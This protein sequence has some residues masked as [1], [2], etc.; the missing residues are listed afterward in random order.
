MVIKEYN[1]GNGHHFFYWYVI[2]IITAIIEYVV[3]LPQ[4]CQQHNKTYIIK[5]QLTNKKN[6]KKEMYITCT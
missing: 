2:T 3:V 4:L 5:K 1:C 6:I